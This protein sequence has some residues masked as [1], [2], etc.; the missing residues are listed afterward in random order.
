[1]LVAQS[2]AEPIVTLL[3]PWDDRFIHQ[4]VA[5]DG[6]AVGTAGGNRLPEDGLGIPPLLLVELVVLQRHVLF[7]V[8]AEAR[9]IEVQTSILSQRH[10][11]IK[12]LQ[13]MFIRLVGGLHKLAELKVDADYVRP[14]LLHL[15]EVFLDG[16]PFVVPIVFNQPPAGIVVVVESPRDKLVTGLFQCE[17]PLVI[18][19]TNPFEFGGETVVGKDETSN[20]QGP[21]DTHVFTLSDSQPDP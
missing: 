8:A 20:E 11:S 10:Q 16:P 18:T 9:Q 15:L 2:S 21:E 3:I 12:L 13:R 6:R 17:R 5:E 14:K 7:V 1:M 4:V 19:N